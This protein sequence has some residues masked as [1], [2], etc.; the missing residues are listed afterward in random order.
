MEHNHLPDEMITAIRDTLDCNP[1]FQGSVVS[2][3][4]MIMLMVG[5]IVVF[6]IIFFC[7]TFL[8]EKEN[9]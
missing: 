7:M 1:Q 9:R 4:Q 5:S 8:Q 6:G 2:V 3:D